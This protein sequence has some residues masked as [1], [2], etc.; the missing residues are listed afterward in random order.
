MI[1]FD[2]AATSGV[3]PISVIKAVD[4]A[5]KNLSANPGRAGHKAALMTSFAVYK[6]REKVSD[7][8]GGGG[9]QNVVFCANCTLAANFVVKGVLN[10]ED[11]VI[12]SDLEHNAVLRPIAKTVDNLDIAEVCFSDDAITVE[13]FEKLIKP[14]TKMIFCTAASNVTGKI[15]PL[16]KIGKLCKE[17][18][19]L[20]AVDAAQAGG[21][22]PID[23][24]KM[25]IDYLC[26]A[27]HKGLLAPM[28]TGV[29]IARKPIGRT[30]IEGGNGIDSLEVF[31]LPILP[32]GFESGTIS[33]PDIM[34]LG[35]GIDYVKNR[36]IEKIY[37]KEMFL[38]KRLYRK[39]SEIKNIILYT[40]FP[41]IYEFAPVLSFNISGKHS[42]ETA[43]F[44]D[45]NGIA[46]RGG[47][48]CSKLAHNKL[49]TTDTGTVRV[50]PSFVNTVSEIDYLV[51]ILKKG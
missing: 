45:K 23:M 46:V 36:G 8:F 40:P 21:V 6:V 42:E 4:N 32:E 29:L 27:G 51:S 13:N 11:H 50:S 30:V 41:E 20:F 26:V 38:I 3:K 34:G 18:G 5:L 35:A 48:H 14:N 44:L 2:N 17:K 25:N 22:I 28:G 39:L 12:I 7:F 33:V 1:Y 16:E 37:E 31:Q 43:D 47:F 9:A 49:K 19:I 10:F 24:E 15:L